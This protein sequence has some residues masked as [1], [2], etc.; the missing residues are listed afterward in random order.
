MTTKYEAR[1]EVDRIRDNRRRTIDANKIQTT[2]LLDT[3]KI[4]PHSR[5][6]AL[7]L[8]SR[9]SQPTRKQTPNNQHRR[10]NETKHSKEQSKKP[11]QNAPPINPNPNNNPRSPSSKQTSESQW[12]PSLRLAHVRTPGINPEKSKKKRQPKKSSFKNEHQEKNVE[13]RRKDG[14]SKVE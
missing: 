14:R 5:K 6:K 1:I 9:I 11:P 12:S 13:K 2:F 7:Q 4:L 10:T 8:K 3:L